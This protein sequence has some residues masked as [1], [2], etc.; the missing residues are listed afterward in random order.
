MVKLPVHEIVNTQ[1]TKILETI[2]LFGNN[3]YRY[4][5]IIYL[6]FFL[7]MPSGIQ[8]LLLA[9]WSG[10]ISSGLWDNMG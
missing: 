1:F 5:K 2:N 6:G 4:F 9:L 3:S 7:F 8:G 10:I